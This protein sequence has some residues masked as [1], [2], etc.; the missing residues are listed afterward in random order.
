MALSADF[1]PALQIIWFEAGVLGDSRQ[2]PGTNL[3]AIME[4]KD[5]VRLVCVFKRP[6]RL[7]DA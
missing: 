5:I 3:L 6:V 4:R 2:H 7:T 1:T